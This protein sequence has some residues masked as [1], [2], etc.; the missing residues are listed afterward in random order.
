MHPLDL[1]F[2]I[3]AV[4]VATCAQLLLKH[5]MNDAKQAAGRGGSLAVHA[6]TSPYV[7][8]GLAV[9]GLSALLWLTALSRVPLSIA[10]P[11]NALG[12]VAALATSAVVLREHV[13]PLTWLGAVVVIS[14]LLIVVLSQP[15]DG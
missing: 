4:L 8:G 5:G 11:F 15:H 10:Y 14:G 3:G 9:F 12:Y 7:L 6:A 1:V 2:I 13:R